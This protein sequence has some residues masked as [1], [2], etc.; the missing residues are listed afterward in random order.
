M[1]QRRQRAS[2]VFG[3]T[4]ARPCGITPEPKLTVP[5]GPGSDWRGAG[6]GVITA[7]QKASYDKP[8][9]S[10]RSL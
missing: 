2:E 9:P 1:F 7:R 6:E 10:A 8:P 4:A 3:R 5:S